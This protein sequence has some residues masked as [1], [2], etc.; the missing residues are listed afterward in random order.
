[1]ALLFRRI[2]DKERH[3]LRSLASSLITHG[4]VIT[5]TTRAKAVRPL[6]EQWITAARKAAKATGSDKLAKHRLL[7][8]EI[9]HADVVRTLMTTIVPL[10]GDRAGGYTR[11]HKL[12]NRRGDAAEQSMI[13]FVDQPKPV[14]AAKA[15]DK[16]AAAAAT[17]TTTSTKK[18]A[19]KAAA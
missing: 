5:T 12:S 15:T 2:R 13:S 4:S 18:P 3:M 11:L 16:K 14:A 9:H 7:L 17:T 1:M 6:V 8:A 19:A 10:V